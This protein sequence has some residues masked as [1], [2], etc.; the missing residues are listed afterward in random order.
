MVGWVAGLSKT[1]TKPN[2]KLKFELKFGAELC[3]RQACRDYYVHNMCT[4]GLHTSDGLL[5]E[6]VRKV[7][8]VRQTGILTRDLSSDRH[9]V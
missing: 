1:K 7:K 4:E 6:A 8:V 5:L 2:P 3:N 9:Q